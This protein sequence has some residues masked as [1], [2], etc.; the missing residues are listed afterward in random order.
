MKTNEP[1]AW[2]AAYFPSLGLVCFKART[3]K[4]R[5]EQTDRTTTIVKQIGE[6]K[7]QAINNIYASFDTANN[8]HNF[9]N[10][11]FRCFILQRR[12]FETGWEIEANA[13][14]REKRGWKQRQLATQWLCLNW[15][16]VAGGLRA[17]TTQPHLPRLP[18]KL[19]LKSNKTN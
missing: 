19:E 3:W 7:R 12:R 6:R 10:G 13:G 9:L 16:S 15:F 5:F 17:S 2:V 4:R 18:Q 11:I 14:M 8:V 1:S